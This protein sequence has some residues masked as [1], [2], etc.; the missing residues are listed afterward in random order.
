MKDVRKRLIL[1]SYKTGPTSV[2]R[3]I[4]V[5]VLS[6]VSHRWQKEILTTQNSHK[7]SLISKWHHRTDKRKMIVCM[8][9]QP[10][11]R[12]EL[13]QKQEKAIIIGSTVPAEISHHKFLHNRK[14]AWL[15]TS[16]SRKAYLIMLS[17]WEGWK[18]RLRLILLLRCDVIH[19]STT[20]LTS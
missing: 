3:T 5:G 19:N 9:D 2:N 1:N 11:V 10:R 13:R 18:S 8:S 15:F 20:T 16:K 7:K 17:L 14:I 4:Q 6:I 12:L